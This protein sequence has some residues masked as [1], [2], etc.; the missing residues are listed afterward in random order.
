MF[1]M[2]RTLILDIPLGSRHYLW[3]CAHKVF[4]C[5][6]NGVDIEHKFLWGSIDLWVSPPQC[7]QS[8]LRA[9]SLDICTTITWEAKRHNMLLPMIHTPNCVTLFESTVF[10]IFKI[11]IPTHLSASSSKKVSERGGVH[12]RVW[13]FKM[14]FLA[15]HTKDNQ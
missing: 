10:I 9:H 15:C 13:I 5:D 4:V 6:R 2:D 11:N 12:C 1:K 14:S 7:T 3:H 8:G